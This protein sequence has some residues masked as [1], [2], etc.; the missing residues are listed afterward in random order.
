MV[1]RGF[2]GKPI[3][4]RSRYLARGNSQIAGSDHLATISR[5]DRRQIPIPEPDSRFEG[6]TP[7]NPF[8]KP[9]KTHKRPARPKERLSLP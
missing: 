7:R 8:P 5:S 3:F 1:P 2:R 4:I 9:L 6:I